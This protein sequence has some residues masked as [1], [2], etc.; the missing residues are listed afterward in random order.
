MTPN[1]HGGKRTP[2]PGKSLGRPPKADAKVAV[3]VRLSPDVVAYLRSQ[4]NQSAAV[5]E[6]L[7][8]SKGFRQRD[9]ERVTEELTGG[10][11]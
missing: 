7:R 6:A 9:M 11:Q 1:T 5:E 10:K 8:R 2:G 4:E 3:S